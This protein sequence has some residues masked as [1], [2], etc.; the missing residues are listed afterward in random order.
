MPSDSHNLKN[1]LSSERAGALFAPFRSRTSNVDGF[2]S[3]M[4][5]WIAAIEEW[6][7]SKNQLTF[8]LHDIHQS[9]ISDNG[10][11]PDKE[12]LRLVLSEMKR[13]SLMES[14]TNLHL[15]DKR[16][17]SNPSYLD[18]IV[19]PNG[20]VY[21]GVKNLIWK[22]IERA[23]SIVA[24]N[25]K[26]TQ[27]FSDLIDR[28]IQDRDRFIC[29]KSADIISEKFLTELIRISKAEEQSCFEWR[30]L[31]ELL[32]PIL[33]TIIVLDTTS[34][35]S[36]TYEFLIL[37]L[38]SKEKVK[39]LE[40]V[41]SKFIKISGCDTS[42][43]PHK[44]SLEIG[45]SDKA[46]ALLKR[47]RESFTLDSDRLRQ[48]AEACKAE[49]CGYYNVFKRNQSVAAKVK[50]LRSFRRYDNLNKKAEF[51]ES[52][53]IKVES[54]IQTLKD[55]ISNE[56]TFEGMRAF[57]AAMKKYDDMKDEVR[58]ITEE[59]DQLIG[60]PDK[61]KSEVSTSI[62]ETNKE[63]SFDSE[64]EELLRELEAYREQSSV[65]DAATKDSTP[66]RTDES[67]DALSERLG[68]LEICEE[69]LKNTSV[70]QSSPIKSRLKQAMVA[71]N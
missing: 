2:D 69:E 63:D 14:L 13:R 41:N 29:R 47:D 30:Y 33:P 7:I 62:E 36:F 68:S 16:S 43:Y 40:E 60:R 32:E 9:L 27:D 71:N 48:E 39:V 12:C 3:K 15:S 59:N 38:V 1:L 20:W 37:Y 42:L 26:K 70:R 57:N 18:Q 51:K 19:D 53:L 55:T 22:P 56:S 50:A 52:L 5:L 6:L 64:D 17:S 25:A 58:E 4:K 35:L 44:N 24:E 8:C 31:L 49:A 10:L 67:W 54:L 11:K 46:M 21:W 45:E 61:Q 65:P 66:A 23:C 34:E 28:T